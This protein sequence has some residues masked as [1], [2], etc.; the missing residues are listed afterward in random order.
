KIEISGDV[1]TTK[2]SYYVNDELFAL[3]KSKP[4]FKVQSLCFNS[5]GLNFGNVST[6]VRGT[7]PDYYVTFP[8]TFTSSGHHTGHIVNNSASLGFRVL[9]VD[10]INDYDPFWSVSSFDKNITASNSGQ[11]VIQ[12]LS[13]YPMY[14][15]GR[16]DLKLHTNFGPIQTGVSGVSSPANPRNVSFQVLKSI[17]GISQTGKALGFNQGDVKTNVYH[18]DYSTFS[19][20]TP[21]GDRKLFISLEYLEGTTGSFFNGPESNVLA[22]G[23]Y[24]RRLYDEESGSAFKVGFLT[25]TST[26][27]FSGIENVQGSG[28]F[29]IQEYGLL[30]SEGHTGN[31]ISGYAQSKLT[32]LVYASGTES[33]SLMTGSSVLSPYGVGNETFAATGSGILTEY[34][35]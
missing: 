34:Y 12:D 2:Y 14:S 22:S 5:T 23:Q 24:I 19:G 27:V 9:G 7:A 31:F 28:E 1:S 20:I 3:G 6:E 4:N 17:S 11:I 35:N 29:G 15:T 30:E 21:S 25:G 33:N 32:K 16:Y 26:G 18:I 13:G 8:N 10:V